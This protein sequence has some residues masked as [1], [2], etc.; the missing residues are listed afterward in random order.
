MV[1]PIQVIKGVKCR[2]S[3]TVTWCELYRPGDPDRCSLLAGT[4]EATV[5]SPP[6]SL[7]VGGEGG[8]WEI[9][10]DSGQGAVDLGGAGYECEICGLQGLVAMAPR[11]A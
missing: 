6:G 9:Y 3:G 7:V 5:V 8:R 10:G 4:G 11:A 2:P 1:L